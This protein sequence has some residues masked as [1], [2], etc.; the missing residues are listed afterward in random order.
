MQLFVFFSDLM[1]GETMAALDLGGGSTQITYQLNEKDTKLYPSN[2]QY[3]VPAG[4][5]NISLYTHR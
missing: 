5:N 2:D 4:K 3:L 1:G